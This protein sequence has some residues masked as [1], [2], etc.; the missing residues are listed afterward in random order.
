MQTETTDPKRPT[1]YQLIPLLR[2]EGFAIGLAAIFAYASLEQSWTLFAILFLSPDLAML[3]YAFGARVGA[4]AYNAM[5]G[6]IAP[7]AVGTI[8]WVAGWS[9]AIALVTIWVAHI[10]LDRAIGYGLKHRSGFK[11]THLSRQVQQ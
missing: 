4:I 10:G 3:G 9:E 1:M 5:H 8:G 6:Y 11:T 2:L 7:A